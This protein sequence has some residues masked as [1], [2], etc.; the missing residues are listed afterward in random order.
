M[1]SSA[2]DPEAAKLIEA[3]RL[4][5]SVNEDALDSVVLHEFW[6]AR[7]AAHRAV[8]KLGRDAR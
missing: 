4:L 6:E 3:S 7:S 5:D 1:P 8:R 2:I